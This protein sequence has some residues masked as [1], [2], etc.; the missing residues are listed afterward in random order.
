VKKDI[1]VCFSILA[2]SF[3]CSIKKKIGPLTSM[4]SLELK[5]MPD[6]DNDGIPDEIE[7]KNGTNPYIADIPKISIG[8]VQDISI[9]AIF[10]MTLN[11]LLGS[12]EFAILRQEFSEIDANKGGDLDS[13]KVLRRKVIINQYNHL[14]NV[15]AQKQDIITND[16]LRTNIL[17]SWT[18]DL[19]YPFMDSIFESDKIQDND[20]GKFTT[21]LKIKISNALNVTEI[22]DISLKSF[23]YDYE[24]ME[25]SE[26]YN[27]N[28]LK[29]SGSK[30]R[31]KLNGSESYSP[32]TVYPL[33]ANELKSKDLLLRITDRSE[34]GMKF[35]DYSYTTSGIQL[36]YAETLNKVFDGDAR[37]VYS[38]GKKTDVFFV[39]PGLTLNSALMQIGK[40]IIQ[41]KDGD[42]YSIE[43]IE[44]TAKYPIDV[45]T[46]KRDDFSKGIWSV[47][48]DADNLNDQLKAQGIYVVSFSTIKDILTISRKWANVSENQIADSLV[49][50]N[51]FEGDELLIN[52]QEIKRSSISEN[53][54]QI[55][56]ESVCSGAGCNFAGIGPSGDEVMRGPS[57]NCTNSCT[58]INSNSIVIESSVDVPTKSVSN[59]FKFEDSYGEKVE[60]QVYKYGNKINIKFNSLGNHLRNKIKLIF[61]NPQ[62]TPSNARIGRV[63]GDCG[64]INYSN[65]AF[66]N[67]YKITGAI[68]VLGINK[69]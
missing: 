7:K 23:F 57:C 28:L 41:N 17:S 1:I 14:R 12:N 50:E 10:K 4:N 46:L 3:G 11:N 24:K 30:E 9:G 69:Y 52:I 45:D 43:G 37:I 22:S 25:E 49:I 62:D 6:S 34:I 68:R 33:I 66:N 5:S 54:S 67:Q 39:S 35:T 26:I 53:I 21:N 44:T 27:H 59:W 40:K 55:E 29:S 16:D 13:L 58:E 60:A 8:L 51:I 36:S 48:G 15:K 64:G 63:G 56:H 65:L 31:F 47:F 2:I 18:D 19:Y 20:S 32:V 42:I 38:D 61:R